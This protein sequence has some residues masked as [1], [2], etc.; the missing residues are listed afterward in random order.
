MEHLSTHTSSFQAASK[1]CSG[2]AWSGHQAGKDRDSREVSGPKAWSRWP[3]VQRTRGTTW[4][5]GRGRGGIIGKALGQHRPPKGPGN[6]SQ[7]RGD[8]VH[9]PER[10]QKETQ[11]REVSVHFQV[12]SGSSLGPSASYTGGS[13]CLASGIIPWV[14]Q[15]QE[16]AG[17]MWVSPWCRGASNVTLWCVLLS[18]VWPYLPAAA[19]QMFSRCLGL[20]A[21]WWTSFLLCSLGQSKKVIR[22]VKARQQKGNPDL[23]LSSAPSAPAW[24]QVMSLDP[25]TRKSKIKKESLLTV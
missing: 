4:R 11:Q 6:R 17:S 18:W 10:S 15:P 25:C 2:E 8:T 19:A 21:E 5:P 16:A 13:S 22:C 23:G 9:V 24:H 3:A 14:P 7:V 20:Q 12:T 1:G